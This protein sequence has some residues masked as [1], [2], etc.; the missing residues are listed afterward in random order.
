MLCHR[1]NSE[2][3]NKDQQDQESRR[4]TSDEIRIVR[5]QNIGDWLEFLA[6]P[7]QSVPETTNDDDNQN[8]DNDDNK[9][10][11]DRGNSL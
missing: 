10:P 5:K 6:D 7:D 3:I 1:S 11:G 2:R 4:I 9:L 8:E